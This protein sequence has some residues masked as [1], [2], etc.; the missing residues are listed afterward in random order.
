MFQKEVGSKSSFKDDIFSVHV[1]W[2]LP[3]P[4]NFDNIST[5][6][7]LFGKIKL[8]S[9]NVSNYT[10][11]QTDFHSMMMKMLKY[12]QNLVEDEVLK[13]YDLK[14]CPLYQ[15]K[16]WLGCKFWQNSKKKY[17]TATAKSISLNWQF[18]VFLGN[19]CLWNRLQDYSYLKDLRES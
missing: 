3:L 17:K 16:S 14:K 11:L 10:H 5:F 18:D 2:A 6:P 15:S 12:C 7:L 4:P 19:F 9:R 8:A 13:P 1:I